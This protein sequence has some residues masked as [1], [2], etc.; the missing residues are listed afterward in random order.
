MNAAIEAAHAGSAGRGFSVVAEE[1][2]LLAEQTAENSRRIGISLATIMDGIGKVVSASE[3]AE[4]AFSQVVEQLNTVQQSVATVGTALAEQ[5][6]GSHEMLGAVSGMRDTTSQVREKSLDLNTGREVVNAA[7]RALEAAFE[8]IVGI[9]ETI[10]SRVGDITHNVRQ[11]Q[12][13]SSLTIK[14]VKEIEES[15]SKFTV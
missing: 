15:V 6:S 3:T 9:T 12:G 7:I 13:E 8:E 4:Q 10:H 14:G 2:R 5:R 1:I 11:V